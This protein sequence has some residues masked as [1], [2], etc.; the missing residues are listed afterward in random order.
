L[1]TAY[2]FAEKGI[3]GC[4]TRRKLAGKAESYTTVYRFTAPHFELVFSAAM[5]PSGLFQQTVK[6]DGDRWIVQAVYLL[7]Y[8]MLQIVL[9]L[10][11]PDYEA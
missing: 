11:F 9:A 6:A 4:S 10:T 8:K 1:T 7:S 3:K 5:R 2:Q